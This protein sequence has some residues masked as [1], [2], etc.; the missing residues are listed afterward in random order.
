MKNKLWINR[1]N[2]SRKNSAITK[3][4]AGAAFLSSYVMHDFKRV[5][6]E[7]YMGLQMNEGSLTSRYVSIIPPN[8][9]KVIK[10]RISDHPSS[11]N[12]WGE[13]E[14]TGL[15]NRRYSIVI[16][17]RNS[18]PNETKQGVK[19]L[20]WENYTAQGIPV[21]E[22]TYNRYYLKETFGSLITILKSIYQ[23]ECPEDNR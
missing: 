12:E 14:L 4:Q 18:M 1:W 8:G 9:N 6:S 22:K 7:L 15:P 13:K 16:F 5:F 2:D 11:S 10:I 3:Q 20:N 23:G 17:S 19:E 21:Y